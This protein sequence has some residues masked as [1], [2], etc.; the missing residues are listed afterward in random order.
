M[1]NVI[2]FCGHLV[3]RR[4]SL[5]IL[6][7]RSGRGF[8]SPGQNANVAGCRTSPD[9]QNCRSIGPAVK[10]ADS[11]NYF[12]IEIGSE[13]FSYRIHET[14]H[15]PACRTEMRTPEMLTNRLSEQ[16]MPSA[17]GVL[18]FPSRQVTVGVFHVVFVPIQN[19][20]HAETP[21]PVAPRPS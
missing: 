10:P 17:S 7:A 6:V 12:G 2:H 9:S 8:G 19:T 3:V 16:S 4:L 18:I 11:R 20:C 1:V 21:L 15:P 13:V 5:P 14:L